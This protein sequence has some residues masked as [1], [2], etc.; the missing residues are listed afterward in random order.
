MCEDSNSPSVS[1]TLGE[2]DTSFENSNNEPLPVVQDDN[3]CKSD[4]NKDAHAPWINL[5]KDDRSPNEGF[6]IGS[7]EDQPDVITLEAVDVDNVD[8]SWGYCIVGYFAGRFRGKA[9]LLLMY[10][11][12][13]VE[14]QYFVHRSGWLIFKFKD[15]ASR[16]SV[17]Q[18]APYF[19]FGRLLMLKVMP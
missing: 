10:N 17:I 4:E 3:H 9:A 14:Y 13:K 15:E 6:K 19:V 7:I 18:G 8:D 1:Q 5:F 16:T 2:E 11:S 12:W